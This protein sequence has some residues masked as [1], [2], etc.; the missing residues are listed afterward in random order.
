MISS[1]RGGVSI[2]FVPPIVVSPIAASSG[3]VDL[4]RGNVKVQ[5]P[6]GTT[7]AKIRVAAKHSRKGLLTLSTM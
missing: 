5:E 4:P 6:Q 7:C 1:L 3:V 2:V